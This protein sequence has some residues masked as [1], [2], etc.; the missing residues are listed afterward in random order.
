VTPALG[1][2]LLRTTR[3]R[4]ARQFARIRQ[5][6]YLI[7]V[8]VGIAYFSFVFFQS[9]G[10]DPFAP[11]N[12]RQLD[13]VHLA[14]RVMAALFDG[15]LVLTLA[16]WWT[17]G[18]ITSAL[19][20]Q[21]AEVQMLFPG[22]VSR[23]RLIG[24]RILKSQIVILL[25]ALL[26]TFILRRSVALTFPEKYLTAWGFLTLTSLHRLG[27][28]LVQVKPV[29][30]G[31][32]V[33]LFAGRLAALT[34]VVALGY[35]IWE[36]AQAAGDLDLR[37]RFRELVALLD[38]PVLRRALAPVRIL[39]APLRATS[40][41]GWATAVAVMLAAIGAHL[42]WVFSLTPPFEEEAALA[43]EE[44]AA[45][46][47]AVRAGR[48]MPGRARV[49]RNRLSWLP[50]PPR[51]PRS[52]A[53][54]WK[55]TL[56]GLRGGALTGALVMVV[57]VSLA[58]VVMG[59]GSSDAVVGLVPIMLLLVMSLLVGPRMLRN[60]LRQDLLRLDLLKTYPLSGSA[61]VL[62]EIASPAGLLTMV[63]VGLLA[64]LPVAAPRPVEWAAT[65]VGWI[66]LALL[67]LV[68]F[69]VNAMNVTIQN[70]IALLFP[71][72]VRLGPDNAGMEA[73][74]LSIIV[75]IGTALALIVALI[76]PALEVWMVA[77]VGEFLIGGG[78]WPVAVLLGALLLLVETAWL[79]GRLGRALERL[80]PA[81]L[82]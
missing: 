44:R 76:P 57:G 17:R 74:G 55:N 15:V 24:F 82:T 8:V 19:A 68:L 34:M 1:Y 43:T 73:M 48:G 10:S 67:P 21:P 33:A 9:P 70:A 51:G 26:W 53:L 81:E 5:P 22:P 16:Y 69:A 80:E 4:F 47:A 63:Q 35:G 41:E 38:G 28:A 36:V 60:D 62:G 40:I 78:A 66:S 14:S 6:R 11:E 13:A 64:V 39:T 72:W 31:R 29:V 12:P 50:L 32:R 2:L 42:A 27:L 52:V 65:S 59:R 23:R 3:N 61:I 37:T 77:T 49:N 75:M 30:G 45:L 71:G 54:A 18:G 79:V 25:N 56:A 20:F 7:G 46:M 58:G